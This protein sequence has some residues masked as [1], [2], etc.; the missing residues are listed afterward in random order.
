MNAKQENLSTCFQQQSTE[1]AELCRT[2]LVE[3]HSIPLKFFE[4]LIEFQRQTFVDLEM[5]FQKKISYLNEIHSTLVEQLK[6]K[7]EE[8]LD[9]FQCELKL[10]K[11]NRRFFTS[12]RLTEDR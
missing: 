11:E 8:K 12:S 5:S 10:L 4:P 1:M 9:E 7:H 6:T 2:L 3:H